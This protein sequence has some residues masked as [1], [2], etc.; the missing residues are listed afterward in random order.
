MKEVRKE[1]E[2]IVNRETRAWDSQDVELLLT[3]FH[4]DMVWPWPRTNQSHDP[5]DWVLE[6]G[7]Y[8]YQRW[9]NNWQDLFN[10]HKLVRNKRKIKKIVISNEK[11]GAFAVVDIDTLWVDDKNNKNHWKGRT[12][13][14]YSKIDNGWKMIMQTGVLEY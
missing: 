4:P 2:E 6:F 8:D 11:N 3:V 12:C 13:K 7:R 14:V 9:K 10:T 1:I 5:M